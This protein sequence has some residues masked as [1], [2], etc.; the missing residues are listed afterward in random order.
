MNTKKMKCSKYNETKETKEVYQMNCFSASMCWDELSF[1][2]DK[3]KM[4]YTLSYWSPSSYCLP[5]AVWFGIL[6]LI[7]L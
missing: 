7:G 4:V 1:H 6:Y 5:I 3:L 2:V